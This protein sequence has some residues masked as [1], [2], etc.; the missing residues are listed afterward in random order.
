M[1]LGENMNRKKLIPTSNQEL[2]LHNVNLEIVEELLINNI[3]KSHLEGKT[4]NIEVSLVQPKVDESKSVISNSST[5]ESKDETTI[6]FKP[7]LRTKINKINVI[8]NGKLTIYNIDFIKSKIIEK[9][10]TYSNVE[11]QLK[12]IEDIDITFIQFCYFYIE[13]KKAQS[14]IVIFDF[15]KPSN[16][17]LSM[18]NLNNYTDLFTRKKLA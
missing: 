9:C 8:I 2:N 17:I 3:E 14:H 18:L 4:T 15:E 7:S 5:I 13:E 11:I 12:N 6:E 16:Q 1:A 10:A